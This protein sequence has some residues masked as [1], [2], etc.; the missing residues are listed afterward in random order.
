MPQ[1]TLQRVASEGAGRVAS[2]SAHGHMTTARLASTVL[3]PVGDD[4]GDRWEHS[5]DDRHGHGCCRR[6][7]PDQVPGQQDQHQ[8][9]AHQREVPPL[10]S[11]QPLTLRPAHPGGRDALVSSHRLHLPTLVAGNAGPQRARSSG[12]RGVQLAAE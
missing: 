5:S 8:A 7:Q 11:A 1:R 2:R 9:N 4:H 10:T 3:A 6:P 12:D